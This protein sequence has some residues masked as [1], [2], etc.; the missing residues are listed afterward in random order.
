MRPVIVFTKKA[1]PHSEMCG[2][3]FPFYGIGNKPIVIT[4][5]FYMVQRYQFLLIQ[6]KVLMHISDPTYIH[7]Y[8]IMLPGFTGCYGYGVMK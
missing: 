4:G 5:T 6:Q 8:E 1:R 2:L 7:L 3:L